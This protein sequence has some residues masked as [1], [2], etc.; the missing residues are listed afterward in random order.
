MINKDTFNFLLISAF[1]TSTFIYSINLWFS[2][3]G[4]YM[5]L[6]TIV[7]LSMAVY[8]KRDLFAVGKIDFFTI[9]ALT[10]LVFTI[11]SFTLNVEDING[12]LSKAMWINRAALFFTPLVALTFF[13][14]EGKM[15]VIEKVYRNR[16]VIMILLSIIIQLTL[17]RIVKKPDIDV[18]QVL[19]FGP[20]R[21]INL[22]NPYK[23]GAT[24]E[25]LVSKDYGYKHYAY[26][27]TTIYLFLPFDIILDD[28]RYLLIFANLLAT[29]SIYKISKKMWQKQEI[30]QVLSLIYLFNP[31]QIYFFTFSWT[32][33]L[34]VS[35]LAAGLM[36]FLYKRFVVS[37]IS[38]ALVL[39]VKIFYGLPLLFLLKNN[40]FIN[41]KFIIAGAVSLLIIHIPFAISDWQAMYKSIIS[42]NTGGE[43][44]AQLQRFTL[45]LA[46]FVDR[47]FGYYPPQIIFPAVAAL[48][49]FL[50]WF[51]A[52]RSLTIA[53][54]LALVSLVFITT[55]F[56][57]PIANA[58]YYF[59]GSQLL[60]LALAFSGNKLIKNE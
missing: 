2:M 19:R 55:V 37:G 38:L 32:D 8:L 45:T 29:Y 59:T 42:I 60:L 4:F 21:V 53:K 31:R 6:A 33:G 20:P 17:V 49:A 56:L 30:G 36:F 13:V 51:T 40:R 58:S 57:G 15:M 26:G 52:P 54:T 1:L 18:Y 27:P 43:V 14:K 22:Q 41:K 23:T 3:S 24:V 44:F 28:P 34:I 39:G 25:S 46:T 12:H 9:F 7:L 50:F 16:F 5:V 11:L 35:L 47:Q 48:S 10:L